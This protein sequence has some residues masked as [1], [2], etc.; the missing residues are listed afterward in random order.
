MA[1]SLHLAQ[2]RA[3]TPADVPAV[4]AIEA[5]SP[6][7]KW[8]TKTFIECL[9]LA[10]E[11][12]VLCDE[13]RIVGYVVFS[14]SD[15]GAQV[16]TIGVAEG[17]QRA[18]GGTRLLDHVIA[19]SAGLPEI[20]LEVRASNQPAIALYEK[21]GFQQIGKRARYYVQTGEDAIVMRLC[22]A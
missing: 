6:G 11:A 19:R 1:N 5:Q 22:L 14:L 15:D 13:D 20:V 4:A 2:I 18:G 12:W 17:D 21:R 10:H 16:L 3:M 9:L 7:A 8:T